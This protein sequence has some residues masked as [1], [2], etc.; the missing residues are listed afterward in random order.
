VFDAD[1]GG[2]GP[3]VV[4]VGD[5][6]I[7]GDAVNDDVLGVGV[8]CEYVLIYVG[9]SCRL[10]VA[11]SEGDDE[12]VVE[13]E[14]VNDGVSVD[15]GPEEELDSDGVLVNVGDN[16]DEGSEDEFVSEGEL[17]SDGVSVCEAPEDEFD[18]DLVFVAVHVL[19]SHVRLL[20]L[21]RS[22]LVVAVRV[23]VSVSSGLT[24]PAETVELRLA[25]LVTD[26]SSV[27]WES[28]RVED[29]LDVSLISRGERVTLNRV[30]CSVKVTVLLPVMEGSCWDG[31]TSADGVMKSVIDSVTLVKV[32]ERDGVIARIVV[33]VTFVKVSLRV[34]VFVRALIE[35][36]KRL[37][38]RITNEM[39]FLFNLI[40]CCCC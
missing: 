15:E 9:V 28:V 25:D 14:L 7:E 13:G 36:G 37:K 17:E 34:R 4:F 23:L 19:L 6:E 38:K 16:V 30:S 32:T 2:V 27:A 18:S 3:L 11:L 40:S 12:F 21:L 24:V 26:H 35:F 20:L 22:L 5:L 29:R 33:L 39:V 1:M 8:Y 10:G 31:V